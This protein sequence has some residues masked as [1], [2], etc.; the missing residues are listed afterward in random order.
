MKLT[1]QELALCRLALNAYQTQHGDLSADMAALSEKI[2]A[3]ITG[4]PKKWIPAPL[5]EPVVFYNVPK[6]KAVTVQS[7]IDHVT[8]EAL[9]AI[10][11]EIAR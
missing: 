6:E 3:E 9:K 1:H 2:K 4:Q 8:T 5:P 7:I 11:K 10:K